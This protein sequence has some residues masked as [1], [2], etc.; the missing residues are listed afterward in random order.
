MLVG[1]R[2]VSEFVDKGTGL[3]RIW[4]VGVEPDIMETKTEFQSCPGSVNGVVEDHIQRFSPQPKAAHLDVQRDCA[5]TLFDRAFSHDSH[6]VCAKQADNA[7]T[8]SVIHEVKKEQSLVSESS[9]HC[10]RSQ[11]CERQR[12]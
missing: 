10:C 4:L 11:P 12:G 6:I 5:K 1:D 8:R 7:T 2:T 9:V 3:R